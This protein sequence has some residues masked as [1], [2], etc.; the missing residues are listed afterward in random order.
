[1]RLDYGKEGLDIKVKPEWNVTIF[2][3]IKQESFNNPI[4]KIKEAIKN[5]IG[6]LPLSQILKT[7]KKVKSVCIIVSDSTRPVPSYLILEPLVEELN[8]LDIKDK[9][10]T[11]FK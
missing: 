4:E 8:N 5:P 6:T 9:Q 1:M 10:I 3:P 2:R 7:K 11:I